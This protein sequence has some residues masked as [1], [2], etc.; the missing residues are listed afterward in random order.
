MKIDLSCPVELRQYQMP[1]GGETTCTFQLGN[2]SDK[3]ITSVQVALVVYDKEK[4][5]LYRQVERVQG[6]AAAP[7]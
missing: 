2:L 1:S 3:A 5:Q 4:A 6:L 7:G